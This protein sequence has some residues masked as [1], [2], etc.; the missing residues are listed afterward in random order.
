MAALP[1]CHAGA[2]K[3][4]ALPTYHAHANLLD[5][6]N[7]LVPTCHANANMLDAVNK[8][9]K[10]VVPTCHANANMPCW[11]WVYPLLQAP[12]HVK[13]QLGKKKQASPDTLLFHFFGDSSWGCVNTVPHCTAKTS[14]Q[15]CPSWPL[16]RVLICVHSG[17][18]KG[19][20][21]RVFGRHEYTYRPIWSP[22]SV[23]LSVYA[24]AMCVCAQAILLHCCTCCLDSLQQQLPLSRGSAASCVLRAAGVGITVQGG[25]QVYASA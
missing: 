4:A 11:S 17:K 7:M 3:M 13:K 16:F 23:C 6:V 5:A 22:V 25:M 10:M 15:L 1:K 24:C 9:A 20:A 2:N 18:A 14:C 8:V 21:Y 19:P 12:Q